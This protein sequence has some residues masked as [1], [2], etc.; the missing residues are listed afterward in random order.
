[1]TVTIGAPFRL[2]SSGMRKADV[3]LGTETI[4]QKLAHQL[5]PEYRGIYQT[6]LEVQDERR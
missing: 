1:M 6:N 3:E 4:M 2:E 5:P